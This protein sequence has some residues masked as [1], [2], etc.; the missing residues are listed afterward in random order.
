[1]T[2]VKFQRGEG[3]RSNE[4]VGGGECAKPNNSGVSRLLHSLAFWAENV[5]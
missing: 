1:M 4:R 3:I 5:E 2:G